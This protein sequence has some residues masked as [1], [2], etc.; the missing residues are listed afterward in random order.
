LQERWSTTAQPTETLGEVEDSIGNGM[1]ITAC[2]FNMFIPFSVNGKIST[3]NKFINIVQVLADEECTVVAA[4][5]VAWLRPQPVSIG[6]NFSATINSNIV[7]LFP[8]FFHEAPAHGGGGGG[9]SSSS[10]RLTESNVA[11]ATA[12]AAVPK[13]PTPKAVSPSATAAEG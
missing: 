12:A 4:K 1:C 7:F 2:V 3:T 6:T 11:K 8:L 10:A 13:P 5:A 9:A